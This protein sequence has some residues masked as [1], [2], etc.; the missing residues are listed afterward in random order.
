MKHCLR[1]PGS[2]AGLF[3]IFLFQVIVFL[4]TACSLANAQAPLLDQ[5]NKFLGGDGDEKLTSMIATADGGILLGGYSN[6]DKS[7]NKSE[8]SQG[9]FDYWVVKIDA[10]G[11]KIWDKT[12]G[13]LRDDQLTSMVATA[14][15]GS[16]L[17]G[18]SHSGKS[19]N[20]SENSKGGNDYWV[21]KIDLNGNQIWDVTLGGN[22]D[23]QLTSMAA[24]DD[25][26]F[27]LGGYSNSG[28]Y[29]DKSD[30][31]I[32]GYDYWVVKIGANGDQIWDKTLGGSGDDHLMS[33]ISA[34]DGNYLLGGYS[35]SGIG[36]NKTENNAGGTDF[37]TVKIDAN[38]NRVW[39]KS[40]GGTSDDHLTSMA[41]TGDGGF[42]LGGDSNSGIG[43]NKTENS[44][45]LHDYWLVKIGA[46][47]NKIWDKDL[48][49]TGDDYLTSLLW[50]QDGGYLLGGNSSWG[51]GGDKTGGDGTYWIIKTDA[52][53]NKVWD[54]TLDGDM[55]GDSYLTTMMPTSDGNYL[56]GGY[57]PGP[58]SISHFDNIDYWVFKQRL[59]QQPTAQITT[60]ANTL[61]CSVGSA[62]LTAS[63]GSDPAAFVFHWNTG[64]TTPGITVTEAGTYTVQISSKDGCAISVSQ[65][66]SIDKTVPAVQLTFSKAVS[67]VNPAVTL[68]ASAIDNATYQFSGDA[69]Q[70]NGGNTATISRAG[71]YE[72]LVR[73]PNGCTVTASVEVPFDSTL[74]AGSHPDYQPLQDLY[75][76]TNGVSW[77]NKNGWLTGCDPCGWY[78]V[79]C[80]QGRVTR[81]DLHDNGLSGS[82]SMSL[83]SLTNLQSLYLQDNALTGIIPDSLGSLSD[84]RELDLK[85]NQ[86]SG[87]IP[88]SL[89]SLTR[90]RELDLEDNQLSGSIPSTL[91]NLTNLQILLLYNNHL[92][93]CYPASLTALCG[94]QAKNFSSNAGLPDGG[95]EAGFS[96]FCANGGIHPDYKTLED[97]YNST[98]GAGWKNNTGWLTGCDPCGWYGISCTE[99][100]VSTL[101]LHDN[102][103]RGSIPESIGSLTGL[104]ELFLLDNQLSGSIPQ[105]IG[106]LT[107]LLYILLY[108]NQLSGNIP[109]SIGNMP[110][111]L[112]VR[113][114]NNQLSGCY[115]PSLT[116]LCKISAKSFSGNAGL[117]DGGSAAG[118]S[119]FCTSGQGSEGFVPTL[120]SSA[121]SVCVGS[122]VTLTASG[123]SSF[124]WT[125]P[126]GV[127]LSSTAGD[128]VSA[129]LTSAG[130]QTFTVA[131]GQ[132]SCI[133]TATIKVMVNQLP[134]V[135]IN[136]S[137]TTLSCEVP[138]LTL[139][140]GGADTY[141]WQDGSTD[142][143]QTITT[144]G[145][146]SVTGTLGT[147]CS[148]S[149]SVEITGNNTPN[150]HPDYQALEDL[151][152]S[153]NGADWTNKTGWLTN[154]DPCKWYGVSCSQG[155]VTGLDL[156]NNALTGTIPASLA[157]LTGLRLL[158]L[159]DNGLTG[160]IPESLGSLTNLEKLDLQDN[161]LSGSIP[162]RLGSLANLQ[163][164]ALQDN[165][166]SGTIPQS[167][168]ILIR[169]QLLDLQD[170][171]LSGSIPENLGSL[172]NLREMDLQDNQLSGGIPASLGSLISLR[173]L[174]LQN[175]QL[176]GSIPES[177]GKL[178]NLQELDLQDNTLSGSI[179]ASLGNLTRL[180]SIM[181]H[182]NKLSGCYPASLT[183]LCEVASKDFSGNAGLPGGGSTD[184]LAA[185]CATG[186]GGDGFVPSL[187][188]SGVIT[189][190]N[191]VVMLTT[192]AIDGATYSFGDGA[193][194]INGGNTAEVTT[195]GSYSVIVTTAEGCSATAQITVKDSCLST[196]AKMSI[197]HLDGNFNQPVKYTIKP[198]LHLTN[199]GNSSVAYSE[200][201]V[202]YWVTLE[203][204]SPLINLSAYS[205]QWGSDK[206]K[207]KY[208]ELPSPRQGALGYIEYSF[209]TSAGRL[210]ANSSSEPIQSS[211]GKQNGSYLAEG[212]DYSYARHSSYTRTDKITLYQNGNL[213]WG[214]EPKEAAP[215]QKLKV[216]SQNRSK[217]TTG[218]INTFVK[219]FNEG[220]VQ[221][222][223]QN[224][225]VRYWLTDESASRLFTLDYAWLGMGNV[226]GE[227]VKL[228]KPRKGANSYLELSFD[229]GLGQLYPLSNT[230]H[231]EYK[232]TKP[233]GGTFNQKSDY[234]YQAPD[235]LIANS[236]MT[237]YVDGKLMYGTE[238]PILL[239]ESLGASKDL[240]AA[241]DKQSG[242]KVT[243]L[244]NPVQEDKVSFQV[245]GAQAQPLRLLL[246]NQKGQ[247]IQDR[248]VM[249]L[250][251]RESYQLPL[252]GQPAGILLLR[253]SS[254]TQW[255][256]LKVIK[257]Q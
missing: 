152:T 131:V 162:D 143:D 236:R 33:M 118:F 87:S 125:A 101:D 161:Q 257:I 153:T 16:L 255:Q 251:S 58:E 176:S 103:L 50:M 172:S 94:I 31:R 221:V 231:V 190:D 84:L 27:L 249:P 206:V 156:Q 243:L 242:M 112:A 239:R 77:K 10:N 81:L 179:P 130:E 238:P 245:E 89:G 175:N 224:L 110:K 208:V 174:D 30:K 167:L 73:V 18:Y 107:N 55:L 139:G 129:T 21:V 46:D 164:L 223:Y 37:W 226:K 54:K 132:G 63:A 247:I 83:G 11:N 15:G 25:G 196:P 71:T 122:L 7:G 216:L 193:T 154:C 35:N 197:S 150:S 59:C 113:L 9:G 20:K 45:G 69:V 72:V 146:Y 47:G 39:D 49:G 253:V 155:R 134:A 181:L 254:P 67:C 62:T 3:R 60:T 180:Q 126:E 188:V 36:G 12:F 26:G 209:D 151:Y 127:Q 2:P 41:V 205:A 78:G 52:N 163:E 98:N 93:G 200:I 38:G 194:Q 102:G 225:T 256:T 147:G 202:R 65:I 199:E 165:A 219:V 213:I 80:S 14:N 215:V 22:D 192:P 229:A 75:T 210:A 157:N 4:L 17:A 124:S 53:G 171:Q 120:T 220:N 244:G 178:T 246:T 144:A 128:Q 91:G 64:A 48:G 104:Q 182:N 241:A 248:Q 100:R 185:F 117:P 29:G 8:N 201:T 145:T 237:L 250:Q 42:L 207:M 57:S 173:E 177:L 230:G 187:T 166:L 135:L 160:S 115:P 191:P 234:S 232:L 227:L 108:N 222:P 111:L 186:Q 76:S 5:W 43:G 184:A 28:D 88:Q 96:A 233:D 142:P 211:I 195:A 136:A 119:A 106:N 114:E 74:T 116:A 204:F 44:K 97:I 123:G 148:A 66:I 183:A 169:L 51:I 82:I 212:D 19:G 40:F 6:S 99:G 214:A 198:Y 218:T 24:T 95:S 79:T 168:G 235:T 13:G 34:Y 109:A 121:S 61:N 56:L 159:Q 217:E 90:L 141:R 252:A 137:A 140:A 86:L 138:S 189:C 133:Q 203:D 68:T 240:P 228:D 23:D 92:S 70:I 32:G 158:D 170:N 1:I 105:S 85:G 149:A